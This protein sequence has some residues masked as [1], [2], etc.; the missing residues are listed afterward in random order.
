MSPR[1]T[2]TPS[3][4]TSTWPNDE[5]SGKKLMGKG[6]AKLS[7]GL[8]GIHWLESLQLKQWR[9][10]RLPPAY[11]GLVQCE[12]WQGQSWKIKG[13]LQL[14]RPGGLQGQVP[15]FPEQ[16]QHLVSRDCGQNATVTKSLGSWPA[17]SLQPVCL[18][19]LAGTEGQSSLYKSERFQDFKRGL[20]LFC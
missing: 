4:C 5:A 20:A 12:P 10:W 15:Y 17:N 9:D 6:W 18:S 13:S 3:L 1:L 11:P 2:I 7:P 14:K 16:I 19:G 8:K